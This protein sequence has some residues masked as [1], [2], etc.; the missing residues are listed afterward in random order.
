MNAQIQNVV[1]SATF[2]KTFDLYAIA[3]TF[4]WD[5]EFRGC[6][7]GL[8]FRLKEPKATMLLFKTGKMIC[9]GGKGE[10]EKEII[11]AVESLQR[12]LVESGFLIRS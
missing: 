2:N 10:D 8:V 1:A 12:N 3:D 6:F 11:E 5:T 4:P 9:A 7:S